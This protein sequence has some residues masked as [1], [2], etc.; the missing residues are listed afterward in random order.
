MVTI[1]FDSLV[2][3]IEEYT[4]TVVVYSGLRLHRLLQQVLYHL[5]YRIPSFTQKVNDSFP[6]KHL[7]GSLSFPLLRLTYLRDIT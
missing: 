5:H 3:S 7:S 6:D 2:I 1:R 4:L